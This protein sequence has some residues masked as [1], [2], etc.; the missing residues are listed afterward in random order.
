[1]YLVEDVQA[2][3]ATQS[4][5][6]HR[7]R[8]VTSEAA[9]IVKSFNTWA[10]KREQPSSLPMLQAAVARRLA[11]DL[12]ISFVL[13]WGKGPR[14]KAAAPEADCLAYL[15]RLAEKA[16]PKGGAMPVFTLCLTD[17]HARLNGH[18][19]SS[20]QQY[21]GSV[22]EL[23]ARYGF[24]TTLLSR[25][26]DTADRVPSGD[27]V[28]PEDVI[29]KLVSCAERWYRGE[30]NAEAGAITYFKMNLV[31]RR[32][33]ECHY[34]DSIFVTFNGSEYQALFPSKLPIFYMYSLRR[35]HSPKPWFL[36]EAGQQFPG[37]T[38]L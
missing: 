3:L 27:H 14:S 10:F 20:I 25:L 23:A 17:T 37:A 9:E 34:P 22:R 29:T 15:T 1:M 31:E 6:E 4:K 36:D 13:Y 12:P 35:G 33:I 19:E 24:E 30:G 16:R 11:L 21:F 8:Q 32:A 26:V 38:P 7:R 28:I 5:A 2:S 18:S